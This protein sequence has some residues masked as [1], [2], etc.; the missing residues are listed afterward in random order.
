MSDKS[1]EYANYAY[2]CFFDCKAFSFYVHICSDLGRD[3]IFAN[4][5]LHMV[6]FSEKVRTC[7]IRKIL[8]AKQLLQRMERSK[9]Q[10]TVT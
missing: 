1:W 9:L 3:G 4:R 2:F 10:W 5:S 8:N 7:K 6:M